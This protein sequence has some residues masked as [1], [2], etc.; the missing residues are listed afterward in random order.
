M[1][2]RCPSTDICHNPDCMHF[3]EHTDHHQPSV[4]PLCG[5]FVHC[6]YV[7]DNPPGAD[8]GEQEWQ[9]CFRQRSICPLTGTFSRCELSEVKEYMVNDPTHKTLE[10][11]KY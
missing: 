5:G 10:I 6:E 11:V 8:H 3:K 9:N 1:K 7:G 2:V 4:C